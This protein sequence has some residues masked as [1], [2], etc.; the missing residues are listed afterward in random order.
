M[1]SAAHEL[2]D[3]AREALIRGL[4]KGAIRKAMAD[5]GWSPEQVQ[6][7]LD[8]YA[9]VQFPIPVPK[10]RPQ[11][12]ARETFLYL[13][14]F[15]T[16]YLSSYH[17]GSLAF[18]L[19]NRAFPDAS[20]RAAVFAEYTADS[21]R[22]SVAY[23]IVAFPVFVYVA[24]YIA[25]DISRNPM[26]RLSPVRRWL[27]YLTLFIAACTLIA[28]L[29]TLVYNLLAG[30]LTVRFALKVFVVLLIAGTIFGYY[31]TDLRREERE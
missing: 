3:F 22:W 24:R 19:I 11:L 29:V 1:V 12:S 8:A 17:L 13:V 23:L 21:M 30:E 7:A 18:D 27:T 20:A 9:D 15:S 5:A 10:P 26:K 16:L 2:E 4:D 31:L 25:R 6:T 28:D 14:L